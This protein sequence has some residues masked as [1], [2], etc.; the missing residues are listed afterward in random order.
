MAEEAQGKGVR[1]LMGYNKNVAKASGERP[2]RGT[3][4][5]ER[6][7][8][9]TRP[10]EGPGRAST[11]PNPPLRPPLPPPPPYPPPLPSPPPTPQYVRKVRDF[12]ATAPAGSTVT[13][14]S[15]N[16]YVR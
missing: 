1:V 6:P 12:A 4:P 3:G 8:L 5:S 15:N 9:G 2:G 7:K 10:S 11:P 13:F 14:V 16:A